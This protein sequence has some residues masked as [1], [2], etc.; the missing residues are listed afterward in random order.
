LQ[1]KANMENQELN[2]KSQLKKGV[3]ELCIL[4][5]IEGEE[6]YPSDIIENLKS[7]DLI[8]PEGTLYPILTRLKNA[9]YVNY[10]WVESNE[11]PPRKYFSL[12]EKGEQYRGQLEQ[13]WQELK[14]SVNTILISNKTI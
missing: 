14:Q 5:I 6:V 10:R 9:E 8:I 7:A 3:L 2:N 12:T 1:N 11:G 4:S 13:S